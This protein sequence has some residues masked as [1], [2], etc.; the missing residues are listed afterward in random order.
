M[1]L[2]ISPDENKLLVDLLPHRA[3]F[4]VIALSM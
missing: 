1:P 4:S 2:I 3:N